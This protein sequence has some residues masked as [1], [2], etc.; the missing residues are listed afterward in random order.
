VE[1]M[2][3]YSAF[4]APLDDIGEVCDLVSEWQAENPS[5]YIIDFEVP[6]G[7]DERTVT[8][9]AR[10]LMWEDGW[11][12]QGTVSTVVEDLTDYDQTNDEMDKL[13]ELINPPVC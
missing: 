4:V 7:T 3:K 9:I 12:E 2:K 13:S 8:L 5:V 1:V 6:H 10:G 11:T